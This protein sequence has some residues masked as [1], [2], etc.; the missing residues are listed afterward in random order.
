M[1]ALAC[2]IFAQPEARHGRPSQMVLPCPAIQALD[3]KILERESRPGAVGL[4]ASVGH[5]LLGFRAVKGI[6]AKS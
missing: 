3:D 6:A 5:C 2:R 1:Y 4:S